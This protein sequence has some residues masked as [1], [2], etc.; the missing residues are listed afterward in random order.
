MIRSNGRALM[1]GINALIK[2]A[3]GVPAVA[4]WLMNLASILE[5]ADLVPGL[6]QWVKDLVLP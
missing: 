3:P 6:T 5:D 1:N 4:Q 2:D